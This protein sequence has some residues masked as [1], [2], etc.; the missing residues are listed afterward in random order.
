MITDDQYQHWLRQPNEP[1]VLLAELEHS[2][3]KEYV[4]NHPY[5]SHPGDSVPNQPYNDIL[6]GVFDI[7]SRLDALLAVGDLQLTDDSSIS[8]WQEYLWRGYPVVLKLGAPDWSLDDFRIIAR[9]TNGGVQEARR[10]RMVLS[11]YD[12]SARLDKSIERPEINGKDRPEPLILGDV[13]GV[14]A[15]RTDT[16]SLNYIVSWLPITSVIVRDGNGPVMSHSPDYPS[17]QFV[18]QSYTPRS[19]SCEVKEPHNTAALVFQWVADRY[20]LTLM[21]VS[22]PDYKLGLYYDGEVTGRQI[23]DDVCRSIGAHWSITLQGELQVR[24]LTL[25]GPADFEL[26]ADDIAQDQVALIRTEEPWRELRFNFSRNHTPLSEVAGSVN[27]N[28]PAMA[29]RLRQDWLTETRTHNL[30]DYPLAPEQSLDTVIA[31]RADA[32]T[33]STRRMSIRAERHEVWELEV[34]IV[35]SGDIVG[36][37]VHINHSRLTGRIGRVISARMSPTQDKTVLEVWY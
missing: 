26:Y 7:T 11:L 36:S 20:G 9:Q 5:I 14:P 21:P 3:G 17:G 13:F 35:W 10:G 29:E 31:D 27:D 12:A 32:V 37:A 19:I 6:S 30:P 18:T 22:V 8:H 1:R 23:L 25:P 2:A 16:Q 24:Q 28:D 4:A 15:I 34:F 33:E